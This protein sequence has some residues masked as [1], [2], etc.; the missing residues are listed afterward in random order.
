VGKPGRLL[1]VGSFLPVAI[2]NGATLGCSVC[3]CARARADVRVLRMRACRVCARVAT[4]T[5][6]G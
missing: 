5:C 6:L 3:V 1:R 2:H 4:K